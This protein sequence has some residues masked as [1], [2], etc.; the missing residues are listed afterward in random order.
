[1]SD[2]PNQTPRTLHGCVNDSNDFSSFLTNLGVPKDHIKTL[3]NKEAT[4][5]AILEAFDTHFIWNGAIQRNDSIILYFAG[6]GGQQLAPPDMYA[7]DQCVE[8]FCPFDVVS[9]GGIPDY[10]LS[11]KLGELAGRRGNNVVSYSSI[12]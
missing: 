1:M 11:Y 3:Q 8:T 10:T 6:H 5:N 4:R 2:G 7:E 12:K 9:K